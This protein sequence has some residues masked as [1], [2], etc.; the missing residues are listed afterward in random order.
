M[1]IKDKKMLSKKTIIIITVI[2][3]VIS[4]LMII[5][6]SIKHKQIVENNNLCLNYGFDFVYNDNCAKE[7]VNQK[8]LGVE[9]ESFY[10]I[11][12]II[13]L[14]NNEKNITDCY[15]NLG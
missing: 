13:E 1:N 2:L 4:A 14:I 11:I 9:I 8:L 15:K 12:P 3:L 7:I 10:C 6:F 5:F